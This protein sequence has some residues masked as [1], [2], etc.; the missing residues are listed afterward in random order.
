MDILTG[1]NGVSKVIFKLTLDCA[2]DDE[3]DNESLLFDCKE[4]AIAEFDAQLNKIKTD[5]SSWEYSALQEAVNEQEYDEELEPQYLT[6]EYDYLS[7]FT[8]DFNYLIN[9]PNYNI[10]LKSFVLYQEGFA[11]SEHTYLTLRA[12]CILGH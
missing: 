4:D 8:Q 11:N 9:H 7:R 3:S 6:G 2:T 1:K 5:K 10:L 12:V